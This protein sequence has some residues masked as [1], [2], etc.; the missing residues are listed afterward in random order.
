MQRGAGWEGRR[1]GAGQA[2]S[3]AGCGSPWCPGECLALSL[4]SPQSPVCPGLLGDR[5]VLSR[6]PLDE[7]PVAA[8]VS[9]GATLITDEQGPAGL[10]L[11]VF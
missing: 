6:L 5:V 8:A 4:L 3:P 2:L 9:T 11:A 7:A 10:F 1:E